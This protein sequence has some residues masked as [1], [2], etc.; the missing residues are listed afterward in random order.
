MSPP[1]VFPGKKKK[2]KQ[3]L[4]ILLFSFLSSLIAFTSAPIGLY[5]AVRAESVVHRVT[6]INS[7]ERDIVKFVYTT[8]LDKT[9]EYYDNLLTYS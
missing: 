5:A 6:S 4:I 2:T 1:L 9:E 7:G 8:T 3:S